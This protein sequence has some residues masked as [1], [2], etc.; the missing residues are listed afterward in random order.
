MALGA[1]RILWICA[2]V[3]FVRKSAV[4]DNWEA[5]LK[6]TTVEFAL[7]MVLLVDWSE[8]RLCL[9]CHLKNP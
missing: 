7:E 9:T 4:T 2:S 1:N 3:G 5:T 8:A 6:R